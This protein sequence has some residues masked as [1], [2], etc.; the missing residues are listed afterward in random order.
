MS[1]QKVA[2]FGRKMEVG[3][4]V[5][6]GQK[7]SP[8]PVP[9]AMTADASSFP[10]TASREALERSLTARKWRDRVVACVMPTGRGCAPDW[11]PGGLLG[12]RPLSTTQK[13]L[14]GRHPGATIVPQGASL[15]HCRAGA[16]ILSFHFPNNHNV[17]G[18]RTITSPCTC[19]A[20]FIRVGTPKRQT[21][22]CGLLNRLVVIPS[23]CL[24]H[25]AMLARTRLQ[26]PPVTARAKRRT[27]GR[28]L[29]SSR[30]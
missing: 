13:S 6:C 27:S 19:I 3:E 26:K 9:P 2:R 10:P 25:V 16:M 28:R 1:H 23:R 18:L 20:V 17:G 24:S 15:F 7:E 14:E 4:A 21:A 22:G 8:A 29:E 5:R 11:L 12:P 30:P